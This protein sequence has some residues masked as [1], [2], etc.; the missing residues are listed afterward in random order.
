MATVSMPI[1]PDLAVI[2][3][4]AL[5]NALL[6]GD[7]VAGLAALVVSLFITGRIIGPV[8]RLAAT[9]HRLALV[10]AAGRRRDE[11]RIPHHS[12]HVITGHA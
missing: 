2:S 3:G 7:V 12:S 6:P 9:S 1:D 11:T 8:R 4:G 5:R 10:G